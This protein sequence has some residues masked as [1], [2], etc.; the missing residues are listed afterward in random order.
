MGEALGGVRG[1]GRGRVRVREEQVYRSCLTSTGRPLNGGEGGAEGR[2]H[3]GQ[4]KGG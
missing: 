2:T 1:R 3:L 4:G